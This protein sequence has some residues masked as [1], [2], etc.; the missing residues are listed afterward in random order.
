[1]TYFPL[2]P[3][4]LKQRK[5]KIAVV[6]LHEQFRFEV[7]LSGFNKQAQKKYWDLFRESGWSEYRIPQTLKGMDS[8][9]EYS[10]ADNPDFGDSD[11]LTMRIEKG[12][13]GFIEDI[14]GFLAEH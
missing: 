3:E 7:W 10:L 1:M 12:T 4:P 14:E 11:A 5:L 13:L 2:F 6:F 9:V 8:I